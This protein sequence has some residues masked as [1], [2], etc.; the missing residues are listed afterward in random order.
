MPEIPSQARSPVFHDH[1]IEETSTATPLGPTS[2]S[3][4]F[5]TTNDGFVSQ[6]K[7]TQ[8]FSHSNPHFKDKN[9][10]SFVQYA[11]SPQTTNDEG[12]RDILELRLMKHYIEHLGAW[13]DISDPL[14]HFSNTIPQLAH[15]HPIMRPAL[16]C[17]AAKHV[18][19]TSKGLSPEVAREYYAECVERTIPALA[20]E[21]V[22]HN[23]EILAATVFLRMYEIMDTAW[24]QEAALH[25]QGLS[26]LISLQRFD[27]HI[28]CVGLA[29]FWN[30]LRQD[31]TV[32]LRTRQ[33]LRFDINK[34][35]LSICLH[36]ESEAGQSNKMT[37][38]LAKVVNFCFDNYSNVSDAGVIANNS[39]RNKQRELLQHEVLEWKV[40]PLPRPTT[41]YSHPGAVGALPVLYYFNSWHSLGMLWYHTAHLLL[42]NSRTFIGTMSETWG[43]MQLAR[44]DCIYH[45]RSLCGTAIH[46]R[47][48]GCKI[49]AVEPI[50]YCKS[51]YHE[52]LVT[53]YN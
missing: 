17:Y 49:S 20:Q 42:L 6:N 50:G 11:L 10:E 23:D 53:K 26:S 40:T 2:A 36:D 21:Q 9:G 7:C 37:Y 4:S 51:E 16:L 18:S 29:C 22:S 25:L 34:N 47:H 28:S 32:A 5:I 45:A 35:D 12:E 30:F 3:Q 33:P 41:Y 19:A 8:L 46:E 15:N 31:I 39:E 27:S 52:R 48:T 44:E 1:D 43:A 13:L 14:Q 24:T 38:I